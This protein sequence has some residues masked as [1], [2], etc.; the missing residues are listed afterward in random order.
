MKVLVAGLGGIGQ[1]HIRNLRSS[2]GEGVEIT[3]F[4]LRNDVPVLTD[5]LQVEVGSS[6]ERKYNMR[7]FQDLGLALACKPHSVFVC[8][9]TS[10]HLQ[11]ALR[12]AQEGCNLFI[13]KPLS[14]SLE[15][16]DELI[17][18][19]ERDGLKTAVGFQMRF[20]PCLLRLHELVQ[21]RKV[22]RILS[23][24][25]EVGEY[26]PGWHTYED[27][28]HLYASRQELGGGVI[29]TQIHE[30]DYL[31]WLFGLPRR[32]YALGGH[33]SS[34]E[35]DVEDTTEILMDYEM[36]GCSIPVSLHQDFLQLPQRR[37]CEVIG[38][39]GKILVDLAGLGVELTDGEGKQVESNNYTGFQR[40]QMFLEELSH[41]LSTRQELPASLVGVREASFSLRMA[42]AAKESI[43]SGKVI[44]FA[45][46]LA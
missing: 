13:E 37:I 23:V 28:R 15:H 36:D 4:D 24:R 39:N 16:V 12:A 7:I 22:G 42:M 1:R 5:Q 18:L 30:F 6:L 38:D 33:L 35:V 3:G 8:N 40:N 14:H 34:L 41:F 26:L 11:V 31:Y 27:Y 44:E 46:E 19:V 2:L 10:A 32:V 29:L 9:P 17:T 21:E 43:T 25:A 20:H 45:R